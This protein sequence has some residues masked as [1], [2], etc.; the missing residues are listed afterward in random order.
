LRKEETEGECDFD[1]WDI[2][3]DNDLTRETMNLKANSKT[4]S[5]FRIFRNKRQ[6]VLAITTLT[7]AVTGGT[8]IA[9]S[10][11][12]PPIAMGVASKI[13][14]FKAVKVLVSGLKIAH[15]VSS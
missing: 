9:V 7:A 8:F 10:F 6:K 11:A 15:I 2:I 5:R 14:L 3:D 4:S 1:D 13:L 12:A